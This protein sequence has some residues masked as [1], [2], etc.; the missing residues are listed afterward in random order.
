MLVSELRNLLKKYS[1]DDLRTLIV[2]MYK[3]MP[4]QV[5]EDKSID[6]LLE[7]MNSYLKE[8]KRTK[9]KPV[10][11]NALKA[12]VRY[13]LAN[14]YEGNYFKPNQIIHK[15]ERPKW[16][17]KV[18][19]YIKSLESIPTKNSDGEEATDLLI[20]I[21][22][23]L[24]YG[25]RYTIFN[26]QDPYNS[27]KVSKSDLL[28]NILIRTFDGGITYEKI[29]SS[30]V[31][32]VDEMAN[33]SSFFSSLDGVLIGQLKTRDTIEI[34]LRACLDLKKE[35][36]LSDLSP[37]HKYSSA[38]MNRYYLEHKINA[39]VKLVVK[40]KLSLHDYDDAIKYFH[41]HYKERD[42]EV[43][44]YILLWSLYSYDLKD[45]WLR[46]YEVGVQKGIKPRNSLQKTYDYI[47]EN[48][49][50]PDTY[51]L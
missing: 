51:R 4:K 42:K 44:L 33:H 17:F 23:M 30:V 36:F 7:N 13:F 28:E 38:T 24:N 21:F 2:E 41:R 9:D 20:K 39:H 27:A 49:Q 3:A 35:N 14:A 22:E 11:F 50:L 12:E 48:N 16:R 19:S 31:L 15:K 43:A 5:R 10:N 37:R 26:T 46:E 29:K 25:C 8:N 45:Y 32:V 47:T 6:E 1:E 40:L 18:K 34:A